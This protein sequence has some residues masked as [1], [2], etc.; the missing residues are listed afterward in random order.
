MR[1]VILHADPV[2][3][4][5]YSRTLLPPGTTTERPGAAEGPLLPS[6]PAVPAPHDDPESRRVM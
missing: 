5:G 6:P 3:R 4:V 2:S 1:V